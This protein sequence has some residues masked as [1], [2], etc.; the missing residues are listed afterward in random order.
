M[1]IVNSRGRSNVSS[2]CYWHDER[3]PSDGDL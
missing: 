2:N 1:V 3:F